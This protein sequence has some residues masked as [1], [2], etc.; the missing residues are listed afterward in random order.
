MWLHLSGH[1]SRA[2]ALIRLSFDVGLCIGT[3]VGGF[4]NDVLAR[5]SPRHGRP[6]VAQIS[7][8]SGVP[9]F[10]TILWMLPAAGAPDAVYVVVLLVTGSLISWCQSVN[11]E[12]LGG[13]APESRLFLLRTSGH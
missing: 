10:V 3:L 4:I 9:L 11:S 8:G 7:V 5:W 6:L 1:A 12:S 13:G 2:S